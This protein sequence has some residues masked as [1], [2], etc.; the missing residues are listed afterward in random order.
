[1]SP[2]QGLVR[3]RKHQFGRQADFGVKVNATRAYPFQGVPEVDL[4]WTDPEVDEGSLDPVSA[5]RREIPVLGASLSDPQVNYNSLPL[6]LSAFFGG[7]INP[8]GAGTAQ[9]W[10]FTP[11]STTVDPMDTHTYEFGDDVLTDWYQLG[12]GILT[13]ITFTIPDG[14]GAV[15]SDQTWKFGSVSSTGSTDMPVDGTV[16]SPGLDVEKDPALVYGKDLALYIADSV[17]GLGAGQ[18]LDALH[19]GEIRLSREVDEK[20]YANGDQSFDV[21]AYATASRAIAFRFRFAKTSDTVGLLSES[22]KWMSDTAVTRVGRFTF[23]STAL[24]QVSGS[25][26][27]SWTITA[28]FRYYTRE[29]DAIGGNTIIVLEGHAFFDPD[30]LDGVFDTTVVCTVTEPELGS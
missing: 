16:P 1:M 5:P 9:T 12:D 25:I 28:P 20:R 27:Y 11:E 6:M 7:D 22:D 2:V 3:L 18:I 14:L 17:A 23:T 30:D 13:D 4:A 8:T 24:A 26:P 10:A 29:E 19:G 21:D 15:T